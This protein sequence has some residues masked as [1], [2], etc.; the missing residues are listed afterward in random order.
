MVMLIINNYHSRPGIPTRRNKRS[1]PSNPCTPNN[2][3]SHSGPCNP[4]S[5]NGATRPGSSLRG[6][7]RPTN[8]SSAGG[9]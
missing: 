8:P 2:T 9:Q 7:S 1:G 5:L 4:L 3:N 6:R